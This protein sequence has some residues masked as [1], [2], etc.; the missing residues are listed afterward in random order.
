MSA[1][2]KRH[3]GPKLVWRTVS[4][5]SGKKLEPIRD[6]CLNKSSPFIPKTCWLCGKQECLL[7]HPTV[8]LS[9]NTISYAQAQ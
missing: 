8:I 7:L 2:F 1:A 3:R 5:A 9:D 4:P 6:N